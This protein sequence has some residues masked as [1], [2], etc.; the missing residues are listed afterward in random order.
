MQ[1]LSVQ[2]HTE[3]NRIKNIK[4][5]VF[6]ATAKNINVCKSINRE[7]KESKFHPEYVSKILKRI[8]QK[9]RMID[10]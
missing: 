10:G 8:S 6:R 5:K 9:N 7:N 4:T 3:S 2:R 1:K